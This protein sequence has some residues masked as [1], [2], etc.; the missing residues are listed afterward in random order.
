M[1]NDHVVDLKR[2]EKGGRGMPTV[3]RSLREI[4]KTSLG[5]TSSFKFYIGFSVQKPG[6]LCT[7]PPPVLPFQS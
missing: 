3:T 2:V 1:E 5:L 7:N 6:R 4:C